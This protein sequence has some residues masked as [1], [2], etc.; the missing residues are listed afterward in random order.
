[1]DVLSDKAISRE[2]RLRVAFETMA[3]AAN[4]DR[5]CTARG[6]AGRAF[7][8]ALLVAV[9]LNKRGVKAVNVDIIVDANL[10]Y[11]HVKDV[12]LYPAAMRGIAWRTVSDTAILDAIVVEALSF[13]KAAARLRMGLSTVNERYSAIIKNVEAECSGYFLNP[14]RFRGYNIVGEKERRVGSNRLW[15]EVRGDEAARPRVVSRGPV[16]NAAIREAV[17]GKRA[18]RAA[19]IAA[20]PPRSI[21]ELAAAGSPNSFSRASDHALGPDARI[22]AAATHADQERAADWNYL[23][24]Q[25][26]VDE[27]HLAKSIT[28]NKAAD[29]RD[30]ERMTTEFL[31]RGGK[32]TVCEPEKHIQS[33]A[34]C[35]TDVQAQHNR[36]VERDLG[37]VGRYAPFGED[38]DKLRRK[39]ADRIIASGSARDLMTS[40]GHLGIP[41]DD[42]ASNLQEIAVTPD[43]SFASPDDDTSG[44]DLP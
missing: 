25:S 24:R 18:A 14:E 19:K 33:S 20:L 13:R 42:D 36:E 40:Y 27:R 41:A 8:A 5:R 11:E 23:A 32:V 7:Q 35:P 44:F 9:T 16:Q 31:A 22:A 12:V 4:D 34:Y 29:R 37:G 1:M 6:A 30:L 2:A 43:K 38:S 39:A 3:A 10:V 17:D 15:A 26:W 28:A 21:H